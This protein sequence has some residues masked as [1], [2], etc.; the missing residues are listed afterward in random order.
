MGMFAQ[1]LRLKTSP[2]CGKA[3]ATSPMAALREMVSIPC[4]GGL[5]PVHPS[6]CRSFPTAAMAILDSSSV[7]MARSMLPYI[8]QGAPSELFA[9]KWMATR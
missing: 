6:P 2:V 4:W 1:H 3:A 5:L 8:A 7:D 9:L